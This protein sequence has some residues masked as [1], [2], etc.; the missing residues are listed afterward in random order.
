MHHNFHVY[1]I[2]EFLKSNSYL[3]VF[4]LSLLGAYL[5]PAPEAVLL[6]LLGY[7]AGLGIV[8]LNLVLALAILGGILGDMFVFWLSYKGSKYV[9]HFRHK[10]RKSKL[11]KYEHYVV[12]HIGKAVFFL[13][14]IVGVRFFAPVMAGSLQAE[15]KRFLFYETIAA[16]INAVLFVALG[17]VF[18]KHIFFTLTT[19]EIV[20][21]VLFLSS[22]IIVSVVV[23][24]FMKKDL[25]KKHK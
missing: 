15:P 12:S 17:Y 1:S 3:G 10:V 24:Y 16:S 9:E 25:A 6:M 18:H 4:A 2:L 7:A 8:E 19:V 11:E 5:I 21:N 14:F 22:A 23:G 13:R 20:K